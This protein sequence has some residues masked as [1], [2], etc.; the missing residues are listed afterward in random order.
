M[1]KPEYLGLSIMGLSK[2]LMYEIWYHYVKPKHC[3]RAIL[4][5]MDTASLILY[6]K[7]N[8]I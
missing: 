4:C 2:I 5:Q 7:A 6:T 8:D 1:N 3:E